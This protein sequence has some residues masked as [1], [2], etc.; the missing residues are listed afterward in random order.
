MIDLI[1]GNK[2]SYDYPVELHPC[3]APIVVE[4]VDQVF[5]ESINIIRMTLS[6]KMSILSQRWIAELSDDKLFLWDCNN[7]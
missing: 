4:D 6:R 5:V 1:Y 7:W 2:F 3:C